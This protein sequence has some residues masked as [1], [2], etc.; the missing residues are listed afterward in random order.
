MAV[1]DITRLLDET[2]AVAY[3]IGTEDSSSDKI[4]DMIDLFY[5]NKHLYAMLQY[6]EGV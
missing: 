2:P 1:G 5:A 3:R 4:F 6:N